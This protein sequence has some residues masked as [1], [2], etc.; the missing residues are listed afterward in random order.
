MAAMEPPEREQL[1][2]LTSAEEDTAARLMTVD[3]IVCADSGTARDAWARVRQ[4]AGEVESITYV[5]CLDAGGVLT[6]VVSLR[7]LIIA[8]R[9]APL[10]EIMHPRLAT[11]RR[12]DDFAT[13]ANVFWKY[14]FK[15]LPVV[16]E[17]GKVEGI[18]TFRHSF[19]ELLPYYSRLAA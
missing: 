4:N 19:D 2:K 1:E 11:L 5:Y 3:F 18:I 15:A 9:E 7:D 10:S 6:G 16:D 8:D 13:V 12:D 17:Q 14:R